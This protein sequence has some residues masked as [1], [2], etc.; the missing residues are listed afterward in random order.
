MIRHITVFGKKFLNEDQLVK[1]LSD[2]WPLAISIKP[3][4]LK[5]L[6]QKD[7]T[8]KKKIARHSILLQGTN[9]LLVG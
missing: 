6:Q 3:P 9:S 7:K 5:H 2:Q 8:K 4:A 1:I